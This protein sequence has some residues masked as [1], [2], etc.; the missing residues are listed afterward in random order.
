MKIELQ[1]ELKI[2][3]S[4]LWN[5]I[6]RKTNIETD[7]ARFLRNISRLKGEQRRRKI[8]LKRLE[9]RSS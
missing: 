6:I 1:H 3:Q 7:P 5:E 9:W 2:T 8:A 4:D